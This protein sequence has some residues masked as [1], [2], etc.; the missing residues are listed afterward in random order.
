M[1]LHPRQLEKH[2]PFDARRQRGLPRRPHPRQDVQG[3]AREPKGVQVACLR[4]RVRLIP[5]PNCSFQLTK[6]VVGRVLFV[7]IGS[8]RAL[9]SLP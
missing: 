9:L 3:Q 1:C 8:T 4:P 2:A 5:H 7:V 6:A